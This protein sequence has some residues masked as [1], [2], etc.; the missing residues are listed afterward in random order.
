AGGKVTLAL[1]GAF[2][3]GKQFEVTARVASP[4]PEQKLT[5]SVPP[6][7]ERAE[8]LA[9]QFVPP[10]G[11]GGVSEVRWEVKVEKAGTYRVRV[12]SSTGV[13]Q[14]K[15]LVIA[16]PDASA[17]RMVVTLEPP[18]EPGKAFG[19]KAAVANPVPGQLLTLVLPPGP[20]LQLTEGQA[21]GVGLV[22]PA[23]QP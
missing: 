4:L 1:A 16:E 10:A 5:L 8:G 13:A 7:L 22:V 20:D 15:A 21:A 9:M 12:Q 17:G 6:G 19:V 23:Q 11:P 14:S 18:F 2:E 3:P